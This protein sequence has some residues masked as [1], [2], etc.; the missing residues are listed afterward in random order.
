MIFQDIDK[1]PFS[2]FSHDKRDSIEV[3]HFCEWTQSLQQMLTE[4]EILAF[5]LELRYEF[6]EMQE[7]SLKSGFEGVILKKD[8][9]PLALILIYEVHYLGSTYIYLDTLAVRIAGTGIGSILLQL[10]LDRV[11]VRDYAG[12]MLDTESAS[13]KA[14][15]SLVDYYQRFGFKIIEKDFHSGNVTMLY[16]FNPQK[17]KSQRKEVL[18]LR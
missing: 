16:E 2:K 18:P 5:P 1:I 7:R 9:C 17:T 3:V 8:A 13:N 4:I 14:N 11:V 10:L 15:L 6:C 12:V